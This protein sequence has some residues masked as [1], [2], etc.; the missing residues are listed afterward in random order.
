MTEDE[1]NAA[2]EQVQ[3]LTKTYEGKVDEMLE[4]KRNEVMTV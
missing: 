2:K 3:D 1:A 4:H